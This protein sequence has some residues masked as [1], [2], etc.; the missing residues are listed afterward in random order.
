MK[1]LKIKRI[2]AASDLAAV[3]VP[4]CME[5]EKIEWQKIDVV[6]WKDFPYTPS[7][8]FR[9][10]HTG[11]RLLVHYRVTEASVRAVA[12]QDDGRVWEDACCEFFVQPAEEGN[13]YNFECN[14]TGKLLLHGGVKGDRPSA[15]EQIL[16]QVQRWASLGTDPFEER[17]GKCHWELALIIPVS[18]LFRHDVKDFSGKVM[19]AN[20]YKCGDLLQTPHFLSWNPIQLP[21]PQFHCPE[22]F[23]K[24]EFEN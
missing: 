21:K 15:P 20:F 12:A 7:V 2:H 14:C 3:Q 5:H 8:E 4:E 22:F 19:H 11:D 9:V 13:Y 6:N 24:I 23:G 17:M 18:A 10:A 1:E 16:K